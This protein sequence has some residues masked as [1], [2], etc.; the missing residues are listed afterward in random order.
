V[1]VEA[2]HHVRLFLKGVAMVPITVRFT[3]SHPAASLAQVVALVGQLRRHTGVLGAAV[4]DLQTLQGAEVQ[5]HDLGKKLTP[6]PV[7][8]CFFEA[9]LPDRQ[10]A[11]I[12][13]A[14]HQEAGNWSW[15]G[16]VGPTKHLR[17]LGEL[18]EYAAGIGIHAKLLFGGMKMDYRLDEAGKIQCDQDW[19]VR[20]LDGES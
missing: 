12:G 4:R 13:L 8:A 11:V 16:T 20:P 19:A 17:L 9:T 15:G 7:V 14:Q 5:V 1:V 10:K 2:Y 6:V 3:I 18:A